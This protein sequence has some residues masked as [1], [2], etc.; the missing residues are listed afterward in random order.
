M[1][2]ALSLLDLVVAGRVVQAHLLLTL[3]LLTA[4]LL[5]LLGARFVA[6]LLIDGRW[7]RPAILIFAAVSGVTAVVL[8]AAG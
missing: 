8:G 3:K 6:G 5:G 7:L 2:T 1:G 4:L